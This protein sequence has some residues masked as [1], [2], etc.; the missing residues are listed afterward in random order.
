MNLT[1]TLVRKIYN[2]YLQKKKR[3]SKPTKAF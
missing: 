2:Y 1:F 3:K